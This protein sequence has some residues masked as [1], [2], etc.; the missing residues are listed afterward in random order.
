MW[1]SFMWGSTC[2]ARNSLDRAQLKGPSISEVLGGTIA[3]WFGKKMGDTGNDE[4]STGITD[5]REQDLFNEVK[6]GLCPFVR[7]FDLVQMS[8]VRD[9]AREDACSFPGHLTIPNRMVIL[10]A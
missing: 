7:D 5:Q 4:Y 8:I 1:L 2:D 3:V 6:A 10:T 9:V